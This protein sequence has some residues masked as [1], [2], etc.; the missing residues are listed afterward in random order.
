MWLGRKPTQSQQTNSDMHKPIFKIF[1]CLSLS[2]HQ[3]KALVEKQRFHRPHLSSYWLLWAI[4]AITLFFLED[5]N[6]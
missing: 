5:K 3:E 2:F 1:T 6:S 4:T